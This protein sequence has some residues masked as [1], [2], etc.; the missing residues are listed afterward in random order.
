MIINILLITKGNYEKI[1]FYVFFVGIVLC[2]SF[3][4]IGIGVGFAKIQE[5]HPEY[6]SAE[7]IQTIR[8]FAI[9]CEYL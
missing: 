2:L 4:G 5:K 8:L 6:L 9:K 3:M 7:M 1:K